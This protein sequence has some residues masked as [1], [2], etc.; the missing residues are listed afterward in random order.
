MLSK[1]C[2]HNQAEQLATLRAMEF[3]ENIETEDKTATIY[4]DN[5]MTL[6]SLKKTFTHTSLKK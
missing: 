3:T 6:D 2:T 1:R 5:R 4:T